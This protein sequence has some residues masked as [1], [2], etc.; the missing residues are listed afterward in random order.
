[1][2]IAQFINSTSQW[3]SILAV[4]KMALESSPEVLNNL[5]S[6]IGAP[7]KYKVD[8]ILLCRTYPSLISLRSTTC[9]ARRRRTCRSCPASSGQSC[10]CCPKMKCIERNSRRKTQMLGWVAANLG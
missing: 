4:C 2:K 10:C 6:R 3:K 7:E 9:W 8:M 1:M 5:L